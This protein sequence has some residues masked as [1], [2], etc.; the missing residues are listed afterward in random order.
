ME[1]RSL[2]A[3]DPSHC[4]SSRCKNVEGRGV[5]YLVQG[6]MESRKLPSASASLQP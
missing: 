2:K 4:L 5:G 3:P 1:L 6:D